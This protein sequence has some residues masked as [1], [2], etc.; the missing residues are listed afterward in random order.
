[1]FTSNIKIKSG[2]SSAFLCVIVGIA[3][4]VISSTFFL[5]ILLACGAFLLAVIVMVGFLFLIGNFFKYV[6]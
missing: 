3:M 1:M 6:Q 4:F 2:W 5:L